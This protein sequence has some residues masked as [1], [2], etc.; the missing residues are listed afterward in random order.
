MHR[1]AWKAG[2][3]YRSDFAVD[4]LSARSIGIQVQIFGGWE[5]T[6]LPCPV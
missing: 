4:K 5:Q 2:L 1:Q 6:L 3:G